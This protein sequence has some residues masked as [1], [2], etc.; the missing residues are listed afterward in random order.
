MLPWLIGLGI[1]LCVISGT[2]IFAVI[3]ALAMILFALEGVDPAATMV[4]F[5]RIASNPAFAAIPLFTFTGF[6]L[7]ESKAPDRL[8]RVVRAFFGW[9]P[10]GVAVVA[11]VTCAAF[12]AFTGASGTTIIALGGIL[13][14]ILQREKFSERFS[15]GLVTASGNLGLLFPPSLP[16]IL[17][18]VVTGVSIDRLFAAG[19]VPG[20][21]VL[22]ALAIY[23]VLQG[24]KMSAPPTTFSLREAWQAIRSAAWELLLPLFVL[25]GLFTGQFTASESAAVAA[26][27]AFVI[28]V[29]VRKD[30]SL[31]HDVPRVMK[32]SMVF[33]GAIVMIV[34]AAMGLTGYLV[35]AEVPA[36]LFDHVKSV[37]TGPL[38]FL[39]LV[40]IFLILV[41]MITDTFSAIIIAVPLIVPLASAYDINPIHLGIVILTNLEIGELTPPVGVNLLLSSLRFEKPFLEVI[42]ST[43]PFVAILLCA[44]LLITYVPQLSLWAPTV[45]GVK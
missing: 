45:L 39:V 40:N 28:E 7:A 22:G 16:I 12:T 9:L 34:G 33:V 30:L 15:L 44:L 18:A 31:R 14:P 43:L 36:R 21:I 11:L 10:G 23:A 42:R 13:Y 20:I 41:G 26:V 1:L 6:I 4:E 32:D 5:Y 37:V 17:Y 27:Y 2:P 38:M 24:R 29:F 25:V 3:G 35:D 8:V 19:F